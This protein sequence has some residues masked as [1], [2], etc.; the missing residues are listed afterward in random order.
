MV[1]RQEI[2]YGSRTFHETFERA[3]S[4]I[5]ALATT[6]D[7]ARE[8]HSRSFSQGAVMTFARPR[9]GRTKHA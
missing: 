4:W 6:Q 7:A 9:S 3:S 5:D 1:R 8:D 2:G